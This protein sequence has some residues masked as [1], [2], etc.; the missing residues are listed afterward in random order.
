MEAGK[1]DHISR[2]SSPSNDPQHEAIPTNLVHSNDSS[3]DEYK[4]NH[5]L[6]GQ[7]PEQ[8]EHQ[9][10][11]ETPKCENL[12]YTFSLMKRVIKVLVFKFFGGASDIGSDIINGLNLLTGRFGILLYYLSKWKVRNVKHLKDLLM[13]YGRILTRLYCCDRLMRKNMATTSHGEF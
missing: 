4:H 6:G 3:A 11:E 13:E 8:C 5:V 10:T 1:S 12:R 2:P 7:G 9:E